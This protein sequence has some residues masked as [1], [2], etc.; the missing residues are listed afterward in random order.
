MSLSFVGPGGG[1]E[2][3]WIV[4]AMLRDN[5]QCHLEGGTPSP[6]FAEL[7]ALGDAL[8]VGKASVSAVALRDQIQKAKALL[9]RPI[10]DMAVS[11]RTR[12]VCMLIFP[13]PDVRGAALASMTGWS[14]PF[15]MEGAATLGDVLGSL[16]EEFLT[17]TEGAK[18]GDLVTVVD[19]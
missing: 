9:S 3:R 2:R 10:S 11:L 4:Y 6:E 12:A 17:I 13:L 19:A 1:F 7:H 16:V 18:E 15:P 14:V 5:V 8:A